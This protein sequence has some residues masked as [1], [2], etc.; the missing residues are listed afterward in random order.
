[1][2]ARIHSF[3]GSARRAMSRASA[4]PRR[5]A[6]IAP[7]RASTRNRGNAPRAARW[8]SLDVIHLLVFDL[9]DPTRE[10]LYTHSRRTATRARNAFVC[11]ERASDARRAAMAVS[12]RAR[13]VPAV[14]AAPPAALRLLAASAGYDVEFVPAGGA[15]E[16]PATIVDEGE[17]I[18]GEDFAVSARALAAYLSGDEPL[19]EDAF[20]TRVLNDARA[21]AASAMRDALKS[22]AKRVRDAAASS[23]SMPVAGGRAFMFGAAAAMRAVARAARDRAA[24]DARE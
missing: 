14:D 19:D 8:E 7:R 22:P 3:D 15:F 18:D 20:E 10:A 21:R 23:A 4:T 1:M 5:V 2:R 24:R 17:A 6:A 11:F 13:A 12:E 16:A 9:D